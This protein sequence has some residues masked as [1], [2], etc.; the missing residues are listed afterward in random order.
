MEDHDA[1]DLSHAGTG[2][3][4]AQRVFR[5]FGVVAQPPARAVDVLLALLVGVPTVGT[6]IAS[7]SGQ[8]RTV[9]GVLFASRPR[10]RSFVR[11]R[12]PFLVLAVIV[13]TRCSRT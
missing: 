1:R 8:G 13:A 4:Y 3:E 9:D 7:G 6:S 11:R 2:R 5:P 10:C 12:W